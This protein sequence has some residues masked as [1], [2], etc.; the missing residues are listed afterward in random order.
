[1][2]FGLIF[3]FGYE[4]HRCDHSRCF[5]ERLKQEH[6]KQCGTAVD[7]KHHRETHKKRFHPIDRQVSMKENSINSCRLPM[8]FLLSL[9]L[10]Q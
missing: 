3:M 8:S 5:Y 4:I 7:K 6:E 1:M 2:Q 9:R 10:S